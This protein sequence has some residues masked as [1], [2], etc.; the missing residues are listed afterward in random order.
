M[1]TK[2]APQKAVQ[3]V[4]VSI[5]STALIVSVQTKDVLLFSCPDNAG[6]QIEV[7]SVSVTAAVAPII[8][9]GTATLDIEHVND[10]DGSDTKGEIGGGDAVAYDLE[11]LTINVVNEVWRGSQVLDPGDSIN[12]ECVTGTTVATAAVGL[13]FLVEYKILERS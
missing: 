11:G 10:S 8:T 6:F 9:T 7:L 1:A 5:P 3:I 4:P 2:W 12:A 13:I